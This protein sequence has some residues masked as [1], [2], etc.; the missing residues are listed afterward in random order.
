MRTV[1]AQINRRRIHNGGVST[2]IGII[3]QKLTLISLCAIWHDSKILNVGSKTDQYTSF[4]S[5]WKYEQQLLLCDSHG[6]TV[7]MV[8]DITLQ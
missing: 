6:E 5:T 4:C 3:Q 8:T 2:A 7:H 1:T